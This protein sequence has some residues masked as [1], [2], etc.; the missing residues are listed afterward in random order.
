MVEDGVI[1]SEIQTMGIAGSS[2]PSVRKMEGYFLLLKYLGY[3][4]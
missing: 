1:E 4:F 2:K 3:F